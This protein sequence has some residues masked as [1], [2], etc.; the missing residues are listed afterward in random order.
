MSLANSIF[1]LSCERSGSTLLRHLLDTHPEICSPGELA[2]GALAQSLLLTISRTTALT[3]PALETARARR[4]FAAA[5][6]RR[7]IAEIMD[8]YARE[9]GKRYWCDKT[10]ANSSWLDALDLVFPDARYLCL[11][12][13]SLDVARS[14]LAASQGGFMWEMASPA[15]LAHPRR[16]GL[17]GRRLQVRQSAPHGSDGRA[18]WPERRPAGRRAHRLWLPHQQTPGFGAR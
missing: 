18:P 5:E 2:T 6:T 11:Y 17:G 1:I 13:N 10:P 7:M 3:Q 16:A 15:G 9:K 14:C 12:R 4:D 8:R